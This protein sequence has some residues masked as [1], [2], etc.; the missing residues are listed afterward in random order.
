MKKLVFT[1]V[2]LQALFSASFGQL[3]NGSIAPDFN[4]QDIDGKTIHLY[5]YLDSGKVVILDFFE[6]MCRPCWEY[7]EKHT[8]A[9]AYNAW[10]PQGTNQLRIF[11][12]E[13]IK[14]TVA[15]IRGAEPSYG[16]WTEGE[17]F[18]F[19][20]T[21]PPNTNQ[22]V[23][24]Y[25]VHFF[26]TIYMICPDRR[27]KL[28]GAADTTVIRSNMS[29]CPTAPVDSLFLDMVSIDSM[30]FLT[31]AAS[32]HPWLKLQNY[33]IKTI[34]ST[35]IAVSIDDQTPETLAW[36]GNLKTFEV[37]QFDGKR[38]DQLADGSHTIRYIITG[39]NGLSEGFNKDTISMRF[40]SCQGYQATPYTQDFSDPGFPYDKW[41]IENPF[42]AIPAWERADLGYSK[43]L[44]IPYFNIP[45][46]YISSVDLPG[47]S[48]KNVE[49]PV[50]RFDLACTHNNS[51]IRKAGYDLIQ[52]A[53]SLN[54]GK[55]WNVI[56]NLSEIDNQTAPDDSTYFI[57]T[58]TQ[59]KPIRI[60]MGFLA[61]KDSVLLQFVSNPAYGNN[62]YIRN[63][64]IENAAATDDQ[65]QEPQVLVY[66]LPA[67]DLLKINLTALKQE[68]RLVLLNQN[69]L[70]VQ[71][72]FHKGDGEAVMDVSTLSPGCY[73]LRII[74]NDFTILRKVVVN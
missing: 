26:P 65:N 74:T 18:P 53:Y 28:I 16:N 41:T 21:C 38:F 12:V 14:S 11:S 69:G 3:P 52:L 40:T 56:T 37:I 25:K 31:C 39:L 58:D 46:D 57:P 48:F 63:I 1:L 68:S 66:P 17:P 35:E 51:V 8:L 45:V 32:V 71:T 49:K 43:A 29:N 19:I 20:A 72:A 15:Q 7:H 60:E 22:I 10:G 13:G 36:M 9:H 55:N 50:L 73:F 64:Q 4:L 23:T 59:W 61:N 27:L 47:L 44:R 67:N 5:D 54:C 42:A 24:D 30:T 70:T 33:G 62:M 34:F 6:I 2:L